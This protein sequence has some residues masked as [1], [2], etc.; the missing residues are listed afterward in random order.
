MHITTRHAPVPRLK[1]LKPRR[2]SPSP[3]GADLRAFEAW[4]FLVVEFHRLSD[5]WRR[6]NCGTAMVATK[7]QTM[8]SR[9]FYNAAEVV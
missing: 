6:C 8:L 9:A 1:C 5:R 2:Q 7:A 3:T 4:G